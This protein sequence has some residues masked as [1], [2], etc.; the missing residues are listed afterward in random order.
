[1]PITLTQKVTQSVI[2]KLIH[3]KDYRI[4]IITLIDAQ[5][6]QYTI[7]TKSKAKNKLDFERE[8]DFY[9]CDSDKNYKCE[10]KL[11]G[12]GNPES[13][14]AVIARDSKVFIADKLS[15][16]NKKQLDSLKVEWVE[17]RSKNGYQRFEQ[18]LKNLNIPHNT[19][20]GDVD[21]NLDEIFKTI[22]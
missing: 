4:E 18:T 11:M 14:D 2:K 3:G 21:K 19:L 16:T 15:D 17:M 7:Q 1:M 22:F 12:K 8:V 13:A 9:L 5:F 10:V 20:K 6:L